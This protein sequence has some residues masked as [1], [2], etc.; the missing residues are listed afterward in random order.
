MGADLQREARHEEIHHTESR[1]TRKEHREDERRHNGWIC[2][3]EGGSYQT[4]TIAVSVDNQ[5]QSK[6]IKYP[7]HK[8]GTFDQLLQ[9]FVMIQE[10]LIQKGLR[11]YMRLY[12]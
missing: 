4:Q 11:A 9:W 10:Y 5:N 7:R 3:A 2:V 6:P 8:E 12:V 1:S